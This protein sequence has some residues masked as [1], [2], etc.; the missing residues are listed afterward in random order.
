MSGDFGLRRAD[1]CAV[2][3]R[4]LASWSRL[5]NILGEVAERLNAADSKSV[6]PFIGYRG[7]E[8]PPLRK[9]KRVLK[10]ALLLL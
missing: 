2:F 6:V 10:R 1:V 3:A 9:S 7:F 4:F 5:K 8:S